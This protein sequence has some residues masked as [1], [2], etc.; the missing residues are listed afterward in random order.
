MLGQDLVLTI[1]LPLAAGLNLR[2]LAGVLAH[3]FGHF[4][5]GAAMRFSYIIKTVNAWFARVVYERD[6]W[7]ERL[8]RWSRSAPHYAIQLIL[9]VARF[10]VWLTRRI[11]WL[12]LWTGHA[13]SCF[14]SREMEYD[15]DRHQCR[16]AGSETLK[17]VHDR[18]QLLG[19]AMHGAMQDLQKS[20]EERRLGDDMIALVMANLE[21]VHAQPELVE[22]ALE[23]V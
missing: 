3:E 5:Q 7:D 8:E 17:Q 22:K 23:A 20:W 10:F 12:F 11:L 2:Q 1:G 15:A 14:L 4:S 13:I 6:A 9:A 16:L 21:Q 19:L 18:L